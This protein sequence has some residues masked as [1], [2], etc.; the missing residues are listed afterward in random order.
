MTGVPAA[1]LAWCTSTRYWGPYFCEKI[2]AQLE[3]PLVSQLGVAA[4]AVSVP[5]IPRPPPTRVKVAAP[6]TIFAL[7]DIQILLGLPG[8]AAGDRCW[9]GDRS[10]GSS[11]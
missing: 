2:C 1:D 4:L 8:P 7:T 9:V 5:T 3:L 10:P 6:A 11:Q